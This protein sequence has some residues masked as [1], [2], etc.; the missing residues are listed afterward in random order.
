M[1]EAP[2]EALVEGSGS[3][4]GEVHLH[5]GGEEGGGKIRQ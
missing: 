4:Y 1:L 2:E 3:Y 5:V